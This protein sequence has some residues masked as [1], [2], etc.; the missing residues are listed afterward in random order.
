MKITIGG[1]AFE[2]RSIP[3]GLRSALLSDPQMAAGRSA[4][5]WAWDK[6]TRKGEAQVRLSPKGSVPLPN[7]LGFFV[8]KALP[9]GRIVK[10]EK[11]SQTMMKRFLETVGARS[12]PEVLQSVQTLLKL[13]QKSLPLGHFAPLNEI[14]SYEILMRTEFNVVELIEPSRNLSIYL[15][16]PGQVLF[17][18][19]IIGDA[20]PE[21]ESAIDG[22]PPAFLIPTWSKANHSIRMIALTRRAKDLKPQIEEMMSGEREKDP[23]LTRS[24]ASVIA[25]LRGLAPEAKAPVLH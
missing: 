24:F 22:P 20:T 23:A 10:N 8:P 18:H 12:L 4:I 3:E 7:G 13:P 1:I 16:V 15:F 11:P 21:A 6:E 17:G 9:D 5:V 2:V 19:R 25:E 14:A